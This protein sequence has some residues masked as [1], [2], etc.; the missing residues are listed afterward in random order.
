MLILGLCAVWSA[1]GGKASP[2]FSSLE[3][4]RDYVRREKAKGLPA[5]GLT[6]VLAGEIRIASTLELDERDSGEPGRPIVWRGEGA[7]LDGGFRVRDW[8]PGARRG[9]WIADLKRGG[10]AAAHAPFVPFGAQIGNDDTVTELLFRDGRPL[11]LARE[12]DDGWYEISEVADRTNRVFR[13]R[14]LD[15]AKWGGP[16]GEGGYAHGFWTHFWADVATTFSVDPVARTLR[17]GP[18]E[19][20]YWT[21]PLTN[22]NFRLV[23]C[24]A[25]LDRPDEWYLDR[26]AGVLHLMTG[27]G[28][29]QGDF[30]FCETERPFFRLKGVSHMRLEGLRCRYGRGDCLVADEVADV[31][32]AD[33]TVSGFGGW[34]VK[35]TRAKGCAVVRCR[36]LHF[37]HGAALLA[38]GNRADL[39][40]G[41]NVFADND[42]HETGLVQLTYSPGLLLKGVGGRVERN[43]FH[44]MP[45][46]AL[47]LGGND[48][49]VES[50][51]VERCV[52]VSDDQG[53][54]DIFGNPTYL[55]IRIMR[56]VW[57]DIGGG[58]PYAPCG[59][60][61]VRFDD[62]VSGLVVSGNVFDNCSKAGFGGVQVNGGRC[63]VI[64]DNVFTNCPYA[65]SMTLMEDR[66]W[67]RR[68]ER[69]DRDERHVSEARWRERYPVL[70]ELR[71]APQANVFRRN[72]VFGCR[73]LLRGDKPGALDHMPKDAG[74][75]VVR[76]RADG[77]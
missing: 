2:A 60:A 15:Y 30:V 1:F 17:L 24:A 74:D 11:P 42:V 71:A 41:E 4:A 75:N 72:Q 69:L 45:S 31:T 43:R 26:E 36:L 46:S 47:R 54:L 29:P 9:E 76:P 53:A 37:G 57:R 25:A 73:S 8:R 52:L 16:E 3:D 70:K 23:G 14:G 33:C 20:G 49:L 77:L 58:G 18:S 13:A 48:H 62:Y 68:W 5:E 61:G 38:G 34:G 19:S 67:N 44:D 55:G 6:V 7:V 22:H 35:M 65:L 21:V 59:Q 50:N 32:L 40:S 12:P 66:L 10:C 27:G 39:T 64:E 63:N 56:N 51:V 28:R